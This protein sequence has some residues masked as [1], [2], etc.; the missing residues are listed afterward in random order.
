VMEGLKEQYKLDDYAK[1]LE[2]PSTKISVDYVCLNLS[3]IQSHTCFAIESYAALCGNWL[4]Y[5]KDSFS[6]DERSAF[7]PYA[8]PASGGGPKPTIVS[9]LNERVYAFA[10]V[11]GTDAT[12][13]MARDLILEGK[14]IHILTGRHGHIFGQLVTD[15]GVIEKVLLDEDHFFKADLPVFQLTMEKHMKEG[16]LFVENLGV[17][18]GLAQ[19]LKIKEIL[20]LGEDHVVILNW[21]VSLMS[22][23]EYTAASTCKD[24]ESTCHPYFGPLSSLQD[25]WI[26]YLTSDFIKTS[27]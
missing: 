5:G 23:N 8:K 14:T 6:P 7:E 19:N 21:C 22:V 10:T 25:K 18:A 1:I 11:T 15:E 17:L 26:T 20:A 24:P 4:Y 12:V 27:S 13:T 16:R 2:L 9:F 3:A